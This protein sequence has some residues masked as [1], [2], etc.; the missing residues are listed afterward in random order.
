[1]PKNIKGGNKAKSLKNSSGIVKNRDI[2]IPEEEDDSHVAIV[3]KVQGDGRYL[4][5]IIDKTGI[6]PDIYPVNLSKGVKHKYAKGI[7]I[8][9]G[10]YLLISIREFQKDKGDIIFVYRDSEISYLTENDYITI[11][12][13][14]ID[15]NDN[16]G[17]DFVQEDENIVLDDI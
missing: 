7:I 2:P 10:T 13:K 5:Q 6:Q 16:M 3:T 15:N 1:M 9:I 4:C 8:T 11:I 17:L 14:D 12:N